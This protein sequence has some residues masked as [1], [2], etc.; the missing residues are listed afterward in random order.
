MF[1]KNKNSNKYQRHSIDLTIVRFLQTLDK[2]NFDGKDKIFFF[3]ELAYMLK[4]WVG[5]MD[6]MDNI[7]KSSDNYAIKEITKSV[8]NFLHKGKTLSYALNR[9]PDYF[10]KSDYSVVQSWEASGNLSIVL[11]SLAQEYEYLNEVKNK[12]I[13]ALI[14]PVILILIAV[15]SVFALFGFVLPSVF[16]V[17][18]SFQWI[19]L[20]WS[21][22][23]LQSISN[24]FVKYWN[25][26]LYIMWSMGLLSWVYFSTDIGKKSLFSFVLNIPL[27]WRMTKYYYLVR[28]CRYMKLMTL[29]GMSYVETFK[30]LREVL[31]VPLYKEMIERV[32]AWLQR[33]ETIYQWIKNETFLIPSNVFVLIKVWED[34]A[35]LENALQ[36]VLS[37][38]KEELN[39]TINKLAKV[40]EPIMLIFIWLIVVLIASGVFG[41][42]LQI[43]EWA[44]L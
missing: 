38:Y 27:I 29:S 22:R 40:I 8:T 43:M 24:F 36:N 34:T 42:I 12:Y 26:L 23:V 4:G 20:P 28:W 35:N 11:E 33:W 18:S 41:L 30:T 21:T 15:I 14:Y 31:H 44:G 7:N 10:N 17:A 25:V 6:A 37:M 5:L 16:D 32:L 39:A 1:W 3:K 19:E 9:L 2:S 13:S